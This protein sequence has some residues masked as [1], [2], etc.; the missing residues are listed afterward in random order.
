MELH[1]WITL[2]IQAI[3]TAITVGFFLQQHKEYA[4]RIGELEETRVSREVFDL[5]VIEI[6]DLRTR[7]RE[8]ERHDWSVHRR[9]EPLG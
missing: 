8:L 9:A 3:G 1:G 4:R 5:A 2:G 6:R 7:V